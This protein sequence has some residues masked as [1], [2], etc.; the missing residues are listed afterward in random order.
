MSEALHTLLELETR[1]R[2][3]LLAA[4]A[5]AE[6]QHLRLQAQAEQLLGYRDEYRARNPAGAGRSAGVELLRV[7]AGFMHRLEDTRGVLAQQ[8]EGAALRL[9]RLRAALVAQEQKVAAVRKLLER[10]A[11]A[12]QQQQ[13]RLEQRRADEAATRAMVALRGQH[14]PAMN[15]PHGGNGGD[16]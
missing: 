16:D 15:G 3:E 8:T 13:Q 1:A 2:D 4:L 11:S 14:F 10:R 6:Q 12:A 7:H 5:R 9:E